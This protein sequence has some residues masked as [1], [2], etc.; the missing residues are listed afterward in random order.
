MQR[1][2]PALVS[3]FSKV[4][5]SLKRKYYGMEEILM[6][7]LGMFLLKQGSRNSINNKRREANF[8]EHYEETFS[9][10]LSHQDTVAE[11]L[12]GLALLVSVKQTVGN[13]SSSYRRNP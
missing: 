3:A 4:K 2:F 9:V 7:G 13:I 6:G 5:D 12:Y 11:V 8:V 10:R 1:R